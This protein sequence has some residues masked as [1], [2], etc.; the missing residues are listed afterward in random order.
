[1][2]K[3]IDVCF[4]EIESLIAKISSNSI[5]PGLGRIA[6]LLRAWQS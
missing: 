6:K 1:M 5:K 4:E 2:Q 3:S